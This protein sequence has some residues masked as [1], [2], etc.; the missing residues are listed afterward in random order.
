MIVSLVC[1]SFVR[2]TQLKRIYNKVPKFFF[3]SVFLATTQNS[4][5]FQVVWVVSTARNRINFSPLA[6]ASAW[7]SRFSPGLARHS[8]ALSCS[9]HNRSSGHHNSHEP[10]CRQRKRVGE[11]V[12]IWREKKA[13]L[14]TRWKKKKKKHGVAYYV[15]PRSGL[16]RGRHC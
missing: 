8:H 3:S 13:P 2:L 12:K 11:T 10:N 1:L 6:Q 4:R 15:G 5:D 7:M 14:S 16:A 9:N